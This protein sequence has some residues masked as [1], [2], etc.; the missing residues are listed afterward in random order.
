MVFDP[1]VA[2]AA[3]FAVDVDVDSTLFGLKPA[4]DGVVVDETAFL[5][6]VDALA[7]TFFGAEA[8][9]TLAGFLAADANV[10]EFFFDVADFAAGFAIVLFVVA[11][12]G[13]INAATDG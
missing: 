7:D 8:D 10:E 1:E 12:I 4:F 2:V 6:A 3:F 11:L 5:E 13:T 9:F